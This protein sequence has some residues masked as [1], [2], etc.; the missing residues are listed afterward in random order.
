VPLHTPEDCLAVVV[1]HASPQA[2]HRLAEVFTRLD[3]SLTRQGHAQLWLVAET[4]AIWAATAEPRAAD[5]SVLGSSGGSD[6]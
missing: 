3:K 1:S 4:L 2:Q 6:A 5:A